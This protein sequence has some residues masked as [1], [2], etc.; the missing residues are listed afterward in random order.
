MLEIL[1]SRDRE[2]K[3]E[4]CVRLSLFA[5]DVSPCW[6]Y[7]KCSP[8]ESLG[9][10]NKC[11]VVRWL[12]LCTYKFSR[13]QNQHTWRNS[14]PVHFSIR[15]LRKKSG[16]ASNTNKQKWNEVEEEEENHSP[17]NS[18]KTKHMTRIWRAGSST[19]PPHPRKPLINSACPVRHK[20]RRPS[21]ALCFFPTTSH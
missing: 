3:E 8:G 4:G 15:A 6:E 5:D 16:I 14:F 10:I 11:P 19:S 17:Q 2:E 9:E 1:A 7:P 12:A 21:S 20:L 13:I 18:L